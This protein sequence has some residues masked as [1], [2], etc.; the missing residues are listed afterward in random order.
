MRANAGIACAGTY[1]VFAITSTSSLNH[2]MKRRL[3]INGIN[4]DPI[5]ISQQ[6]QTRNENYYIVTKVLSSLLLI[7]LAT[8]STNNFYLYH[9]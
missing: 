9:F 5:V 3:P 2:S 8:E 4:K 6:F 1:R 7:F